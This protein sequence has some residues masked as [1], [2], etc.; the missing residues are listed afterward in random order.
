ML[1]KSQIIILHTIKHGDSGMVVQAYSNVF[2]R[3]SLYLRGVSK[4]SVKFSNIHKLSILD[5]VAYTNGTQ[6]MPTIKEINTPYKLISLKTDI[7][8][9]SIAIF[10]SELLSKCVKEAEQNPILYNYLSSSIQIL[11]HT[12]NGIANFHIHFITHL[13]KMLGFMPLDNYSLTTPIF[14]LSTAKFCATQHVAKY[15]S[16]YL[17]TSESEL[18]HCLI[19]TPSTNL[20][21]LKINNRVLKINRDIRYNFTKRMIDYLSLHIGNTI[22]IKSLDIL[23][24]IFS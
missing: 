6:S 12:T 22:E 20:E 3:Q 18:L 14:D 17:D 7:Y 24:Q 10:I 9:S 5:I 1:T 13:T 21:E 8:K 2:G 4:H 16:C 11:E 19:N 15:G 23:H